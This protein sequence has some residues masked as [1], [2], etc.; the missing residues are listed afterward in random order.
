MTWLIHILIDSLVLLLASKAMPSVQ[1]KSFK[2][3]LLVALFVG[4]VSF[5]IGWLFTLILNVATLGIF[6]FLG[7][8]VVTRIISNAIIIEIADQFSSGF[9]TDG[10]M[11]SLYLAIIIAIVG[12]L[13][14]YFLF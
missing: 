8:G 10:F 6:F 3:A 7:L 5:L 14:D 9:K 4:I 12:G 11:P 2:T 1:V 13:V